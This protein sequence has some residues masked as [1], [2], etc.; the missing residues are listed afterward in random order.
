MQ[1]LGFNLEYSGAAMVLYA[2]MLVSGNPLTDLLSI[3]GKT[4]LTGPDPPAPATVAGLSSHNF[5]EGDGSMTRGKYSPLRP[6]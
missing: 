4:E 2:A 1:N 5:F 6:H 3:G